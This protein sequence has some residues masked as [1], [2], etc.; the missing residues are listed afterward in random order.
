MA[1]FNYVKKIVVIISFLLTSTGYAQWNVVNV[2][3]VNELNGV[4]YTS[5]SL[6]FIGGDD[7][8]I[9]SIDGG[10]TWIMLPLYDNLGNPITGSSLYD[11]HFFDATTGLS[12]GQITMANSEVILRTVNGGS[13]WSSASVYNGGSWPRLQQ[14]LFF[15]NSNLGYSA[16]SNG[17]IL[18]TSNGGLTWSLQPA[19]ISNELKGICF[20]SQDTGVA[21]GQY[22]I[23]YTNN[24]GASWTVNSYPSKDF[25]AVHFPTSMVGYA[26]GLN[27]ALMKSNNKG[28][29]WT[30]IA[31]PVALVNTNFADVFFTSIDTGYIIAGNYLLKTMNGGLYWSKKRIGNVQLN[32]LHFLDDNNAYVV[33]ENGFVAR[34]SNAGGLFG[35][36]ASFTHSVIQNCGTTTLQFS[37]QSDPALGYKWY[38]NGLLMSTSYNYTQVYSGADVDTFKLV[39]INGCCS[40]TFVKVISIPIYNPIVASVTS[41][42]SICFGNSLSLNASGGSN[43]SWS[44]SVGLSSTTIAN[45]VTTLTSSVT[46]SVVV[47]DAYGVCRDTAVVN[48]NVAA[49]IAP[50]VWLKLNLSVPSML[51]SIDFVDANHGFGISSQSHFVKTSDG[52]NTWVV[53]QPFFG[54]YSCE[55]D[56][57][58]PLNGYVANNGLFKTIDG[59]V[60]FSNVPTVPMG[61]LSRLFFLNKDTGWVASN[62]ATMSSTKT[63]AKTTDGGKTWTIQHT[64]GYQ[65]DIMKLFCINKDTCYCVGG[66]ANSSS[67]Y[68]RTVNGGVNWV[69]IPVNSNIQLQ[70]IEFA[71]PDHGFIASNLKSTDGGQIW[72]SAPM[73][74]SYLRTIETI[75]NDTIYAGGPLAQSLGGHVFKT[76][77]GGGCWQKMT[78]LS[79]TGTLNDIDFPI[80]QCGYIACDSNG[81]NPARIYKTSSGRYLDFSTSKSLCTGMKIHL[82]NGAIG[83]NTYKWL[84]NG[85]AYSVSMDTAVVLTIPGTY[86]ISLVGFSAV[87]DTVN[88]IIQI[89]STPIVNA[90]P[91]ITACHNTPIQFNAMVSGGNLPLS[92][93]WSSTASLNNLTISNPVCT[94]LYNESFT[95]TVTSANGCSSSDNLLLKLNYPPNVN[96][97]ADK[98]ICANSPINVTGT[99][100]N[101]ITFDWTSSGSGT[102]SNADSSATEYIPSISDLSNGMVSLTFVGSAAPCINDSDIVNIYFLSSPTANAG[103]DLTICKGSGAGLIGS[104][105]VLYSWAPSNGLSCSLCSNPIASPTTTTTYVLYAYATNYCWDLDSMEVL[106][107]ICSNSDAKYLITQASILG[108]PISKESALYYQTK[109]VL[110]V[111][112]HLQD[113][114]GRQSLLYEKKS[115]PPGNHYVPLFS[116]LEKSPPGIYFIRLKADQLVYYLKVIVP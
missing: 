92:Y 70:D 82:F 32:A 63:I 105:G 114:I 99:Y 7:G 98:S 16:G 45:P 93:Q 46:Y 14:D 79:N 4:E 83:Y 64:G 71:D 89:K 53:S 43:Y 62:G 38:R 95:V 84:I 90:G 3:S 34:S 103:S 50:D 23:V 115:E 40:D 48:V 21:V 39:A 56:F 57:I 51:Q 96:A 72:T 9:K 85:L 104:G 2:G 25:T 101:A 42:T 80:S 54:Q 65:M 88:K 94:P 59:G 106:V 91:D 73:G 24:G 26:V 12:T 10:V 110:D 76:I 22:V 19:G 44:P 67:M 111:E 35:P 28:A 18:K 86:T 31:L 5:S 37:N 60:T 100:T 36:V 107:V 78:T 61:Q 29:N 87:N 11:V 55:V 49:S 112:I 108:N 66:Y 75:S 6:I 27:G 33:G 20:N 13:N 41:D 17:R 77:N 116:E 97:G 52:G 102:F 74:S 8:L 58:D 68:L 109:E 15:V 69:N 1:Y 81:V 113:L 30:D 47:L